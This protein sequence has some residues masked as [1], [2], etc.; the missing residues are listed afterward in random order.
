[1]VITPVGTTFMFQYSI[2]QYDITMRNDIANE[3]HFEV[4]I[5]NDISICTYHDI[6]MDNDIAMGLFYYVLVQPIM[7]L[8]LSP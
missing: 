1:M 6:T 7:V 4:T 2:T 3:V 8:L 5:N